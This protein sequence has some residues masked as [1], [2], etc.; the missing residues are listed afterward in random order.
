[1]DV[2]RYVN[3]FHF[4][5]FILLFWVSGLVL[6]KVGKNEFGSGEESTDH[7]WIAVEEKVTAPG[8]YCIN[9]VFTVVC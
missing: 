8:N 7:F 4:A 1:M 9:S 3:K 2:W 6:F 5:L